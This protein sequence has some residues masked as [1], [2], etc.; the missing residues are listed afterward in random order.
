MQASDGG[1]YRLS[2]V[3]LTELDAIKG[4]RI[5]AGNDHGVEIPLRDVFAGLPD[6]RSRGE[7]E[8]NETSA[9]G[10]AGSTT[11]RINSAWRHCASR[12]AA[13]LCHWASSRDW[14]WLVKSS[15]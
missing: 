8:P 3:L 5:I 14:P 4:S 1:A 12:V 13:C 15:S 11:Q 7:S 9:Y 10:C 6:K 2:E